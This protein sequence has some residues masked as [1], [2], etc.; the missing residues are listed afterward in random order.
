[1]KA[2]WVIFSDTL[3]TSGRLLGSELDDK[4]TEV[5][6]KKIG[7]EM[8]DCPFKIVVCSYGK[9]KIPGAISGKSES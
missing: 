7:E 2:G 3:L 6:W 8:A 5:N 4:M 9:E 1:M